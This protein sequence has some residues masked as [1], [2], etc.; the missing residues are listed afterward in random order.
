MPPINLKY[1]S[2]LTTADG[3][4]IYYYGVERRVELTSLSK[5]SKHVIDALIATEDREFYEHDGV[6]VRGLGRAIFSTMTGN[7]QGGSTLTMQLARNLF[8]SHERTISRKLSEID[9]ARKLETKYSKKEL[10]L[11]YLNTVYFGH[12]CYGIWTA[13]QEYFNK[14]PDKLTIQESAMLIGMLKAPTHYDPV[15]YPEKVIKR[16]NEVMYNLVETGKL[17]DKEY[18]KL[19]KT[20]LGLKM[21]E[22]IALHFAEYIRRR[23]EDL[24]RSLRKNLSHDQLAITTTLDFQAQTAAEAALTQQYKVLPQNMKDVQVGLVSVEPATGY[25][26]AMIGGNPDSDMMGWNH[27]TQNR[28]QVGSAF[29]P[30]L[31][32]SLLERGYTLGTPLMD[33]PVVVDSGTAWEWRPMNDENTFTGGPVPMKFAIQESLNLAAANAVTTLTNP[34]ELAAFARR[35]GIRSPLPL[36]PSLALGTGELS[37]LEMASALA[38]FPAYGWYAEPVGI[39]KIAEQKGKTL[40]TY[41]PK[42]EQVTDSATCYL[43]TDALQTVVN[44]GTASVIRRFYKGPA[45]GKTG[46][47]Q[48]SADAWFAGY[49]PSLTTVVW[50]GFG[51]Q[52][53]KLTGKYQYGGTVAAPMWGRMMGELAKKRPLMNKQ[54]WLRPETVLDMPVCL[55]N[56]WV[57]Q[58]GCIQTAIYP[59][60]VPRLPIEFF[61]L[62]TFPSLKP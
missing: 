29:K 48:G 22:P 34:D 7:T 32:A 60:K 47:T 9:Y 45:A 4:V 54:Q 30:F 50:Y 8:L 25:I 18:K 16:R 37:P 35:M 56:G 33:A 61:D 59:V 3:K 43:L 2:Y 13:A 24:L 36:V 41:T 49:T 28:R 40:Y 21:R 39:L 46:T 10:L 23:S 15:K 53:K 38:V 14:P 58:P 57:H 44:A 27:A 19:R 6:S 5:V 26:R 51:D 31:Y 11:L 12:K 20:E 1:A 17:S 42:P 52:R 62:L 55:D